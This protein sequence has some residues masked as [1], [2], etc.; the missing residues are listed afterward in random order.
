MNKNSNGRARLCLMASLWVGA[1]AG[2]SAAQQVIEVQ[3][4]VVFDWVTV[5]DPG[6]ANDFTGRGRV[7]LVYR[8][9]SLEVTNGQYAVFLNA[10][11]RLA[12]PFG[13]W[14]PAMGSDPRGGLD[15]TGSG[16]LLD[17]FVYVPKVDMARKPVNYVSW[18]D[19]VRFVNWLENGQA[20]GDTED[21]S[22]TLLGG[23]IIPT[24]GES[25]QRNNGSQIWLPRED[26]WY[27]AAYYNG[28]TQGY[29]LY[30]TQSNQIPQVASATPTGA[31]AN[32]GP[33]VANHSLGAAWGGV[34]GHLTTVGS[35]GATSYYGCHD[36]NGNVYEWSETIFVWNSSP[37]RVS[38]SGS[39][40]QDE[41]SLP[42]TS[43]VIT[44]P[45]VEQVAVGFRVARKR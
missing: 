32:P 11:A 2:A 24:N 13:L 38:R 45:W 30:A 1:L 15:R 27:K 40:Q 34:Q 5:G 4:R 31:V 23:S 33:N 36:M 43:F 21:G 41:T 14:N 39:F 8:I 3:P 25:V 7:N 42:S 18:F 6:N 28:A 19:C 12:D 29:S 35:A 22:Y 20:D 16:T 9:S 37:Y 44:K 10:K 17:P 26:Q